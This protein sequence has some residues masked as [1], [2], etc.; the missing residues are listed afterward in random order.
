MVGF[1][2]KKV[3]ESSGSIETGIFEQLNKCNFVT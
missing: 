3:K 1:I 2:I